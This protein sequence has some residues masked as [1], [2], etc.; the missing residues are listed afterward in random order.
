V[1]H[2]SQEE[3]ETASDTNAHVAE[4]AKCRDAVK[5]ARG[6]QNLMKGMR[7]YTLSGVAF[8][9]VDAK[10]QEHV[11]EARSARPWWLYAFGGVA[12]AAAIAVAVLVNLPGKPAVFEPMTVA[13]AQGETTLKAGDVLGRGTQ[14]ASGDANVMLATADGAALRLSGGAGYELGIRDAAVA[15]DTGRL[16]V[17]AARGGPWRVRVGDH[18][19]ESSDALMAVSPNAVDLARGSVRVSEESWLRR[20]RV[21]TAPAHLD[22]RTGA[23]TPLTA[24]VAAL[25]PAVKPP[26][27][28]LSL[29]MTSDSVELDGQKLG[30]SPLS[31]LTTPGRHHL[32][33]A[34]RESDIDLTTTGSGIVEL[35]EKP[36]VAAP[37]LPKG[38]HVD[39]DPEAIAKAIRAQLPKLRV[40]HDKWLKVDPA[41]K[42][43]VEMTLTVSPQ[44]RVTKTAF[45]AAEG[46]PP[47]IDACLA[48][49]A[50]LLVL[51]KSSEEVEL[52][53]PV[54]LGG[55]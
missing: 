20:S 50:R 11:R 30:P 41:A 15:F 28:K 7:P 27:A 1:S 45:T 25:A 38:P 8:S 5:L 36:I 54:L 13:S 17:D 34:G 2:L 39:A 23:V 42:G 48:H 33:A 37:A 44:G 40:C 24:E 21:V 29:A 53:L 35:P 14:V 9:R 46:V 47:G 49:E 10:L 52:E 43:K 18:F 32:S 4:C 12:A 6:R 55:Q 26:F 16:V 19:L 51:P 3:L 31:A 22:L